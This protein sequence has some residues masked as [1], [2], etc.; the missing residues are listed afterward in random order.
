ML[1]IR[2]CDKLVRWTFRFEFLFGDKLV[3]CSVYLTSN[4]LLKSSFY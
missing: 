2:M 1:F 4:L 3:G